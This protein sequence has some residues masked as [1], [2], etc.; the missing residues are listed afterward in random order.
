MRCIPSGED[1]LHV[2]TASYFGISYLV[3]WNYE[4]LVKVKTR[5]LVNLVNTLE[6][7]REIETISPLEL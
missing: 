2:A 6:G 3:S 1:S 7:F 4:H 5:R